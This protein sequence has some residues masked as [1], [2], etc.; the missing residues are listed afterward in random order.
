MQQARGCMEW[1]GG[2]SSGLF[3]GWLSGWFDAWLGGLG[4]SCDGT[5]MVLRYRVAGPDLAR[6]CFALPQMG[7]TPK[8]IKPATRA[9]QRDM[10][11]NELGH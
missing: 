3:S 5:T 10:A 4:L 9:S 11:G 2:L 1:L 8:T 7:Q 6:F